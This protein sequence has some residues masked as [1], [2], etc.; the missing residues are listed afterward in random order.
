MD[1]NIIIA[2]ILLLFIIYVIYEN[3][4]F[5]ITH[6][7]IHSKRIPKAFEGARFVILAD[8]HNNKFGKENKR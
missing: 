3:Q 6:Y 7:N 4:N 5:E 8:L 2:V 1:R